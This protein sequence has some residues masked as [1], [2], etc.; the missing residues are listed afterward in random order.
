MTDPSFGNDHEGRLARLEERQD[1]TDIAVEALQTAF[2]DL[3]NAFTAYTTATNQTIADILAKE[4][5]G[6]TI[7]GSELAP[8]TA[9][10]T[11]LA[12]AV[13][14][15][16][17]IIAAEDPGAPAPEAKPLYIH[18]TDGPTEGWTLTDSEVPSVAAVPAGPDGEPEALEVPAK[19]LWNFD[20]DTAGGAPTGAVEGVWTVYTGPTQPVPAA[21]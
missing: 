12:T 14:A 17:A 5:A 4:S 7:T 15:A 6:G 2:T 3:S 9:G 10:A 8:I 18:D 20:A 11:A 21:E 16:T 19:P 13:E 1:M